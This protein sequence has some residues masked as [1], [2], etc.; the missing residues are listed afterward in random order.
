MNLEKISQYQI[1]ENNKLRESIHSKTKANLEIR[2][3]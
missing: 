2:R 1:W 3:K